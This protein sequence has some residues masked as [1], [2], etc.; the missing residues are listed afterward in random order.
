[1][2]ATVLGQVARP[3]AKEAMAAEARGYLDFAHRALRPE[4]CRLIAIGGVSGTGK[5]TLAAALAPELGVRPGARV[6]RSDVTRK[7]LFDVDPE[8]RLPA[9]AYKKEIS[10]RVYDTLRRKAAM[11]LAAGCSVII[12]AVALRPQER[13]AFAEV[14]RVA[15][16]PFWGLWL[17]APAATMASRIGARRRDASDATAKIL[18]DQLRHD[19]GPIDWIRID[20]GGGPEDCL[21]AAQRALRGGC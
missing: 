21:A 19:P 8:T 10:Q 17:E 6:L 18:A 3:N 16:V 2:T 20:A 9:S 1:V 11:G 5:S 4:P 13:R 12:D 15:G 7:L 14:A